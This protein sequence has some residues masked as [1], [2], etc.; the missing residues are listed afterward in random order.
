MIVYGGNA[1]DFPH[2]NRVNTDL[3][4]EIGL[5]PTGPQR[6]ENSPGVP[7]TAFLRA[8]EIGFRRLQANPDMGDIGVS[9]CSPSTG[10][11]FLIS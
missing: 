10:L 3:L 9:A 7:A 5:Y 11:S 2:E 1:A 6:I 8:G 4:P